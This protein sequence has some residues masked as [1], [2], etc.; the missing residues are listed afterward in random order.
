MSHDSENLSETTRLSVDGILRQALPSRQLHHL[1]VVEGAA[2]GRILELGPTP[3]TIGRDP[4]AVLSLPVPG[5]SRAHARVFLSESGE[6]AILED[7][8]SKNGTFVNKVLVERAVLHDEDV[9]F[10]GTARVKYLAPGNVEHAYFARL[11]AATRLDGLT[12]LLNR[13][14]F[15]DTLERAFRAARGSQR[16]LGLL[17]ADIDHFKRV[18][19]R[20]GHLAGDHVLR[21]LAA[22]LRRA[23]RPGDSA[24]RYGGEEFAT[25]LPDTPEPAVFR[26]AERLR[27]AVAAF[28]FRFGELSLPLTVSVGG[29]VLDRG[30]TEP[31][32][33]VVRADEALYA[34]K[35]GGRN[36]VV[37]Y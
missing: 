21:D 15:D 6:E 2:V 18:N 24:C 11:D 5:A 31:N 30:M 35:E 10:I 7:V 37:V 16:S 3:V 26:L 27:A 36:R 12:G 20:H 33:L 14:V 25:I 29:A 17:I 28:H 19:D 32:E 34:A 23:T 22:I 8:G 4:N 13:R 1:V 9:I